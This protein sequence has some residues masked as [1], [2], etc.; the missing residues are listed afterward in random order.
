MKKVYGDDFYAKQMQASYES[1]KVYVDLLFRI[2]APAT[3]VDVGCGRGTWLK[4]FGEAGAKRLV[5]LDG[6]WNSQ[7]N[8]ADAAIAFTAVDLNQRL[9]MP[10]T[11]RFDVAM[12]L[13][14]AEHLEPDSSATF[15][16]SLTRL[17]DVVLFGAAFPGQG[18]A[19]HINEQLPSYWARLF[20]ERGYAPFDVFRPLVW[21]DDRVCFWYR[22]NAFLYIR[23][24]SEA[25][26][27]MRA[28]GLF[29]M[30]DT[31][32]MNCVHPE[33]LFERNRQSVSRGF[34]MIRKSIVRGI[35]GLGRGNDR[36]SVVHGGQA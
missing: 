12:S 23:E 4:A 29:P 21:N 18:G 34:K 9:S 2:F 20:H 16:E 13:E 5:G 3:V 17:S 8:M 6:R 27:T 26:E 19:N 15:V 10:G 22:Q 31:A 30:R 25:W 1:A 24:G 33:L 7:D 35:K 36:K 11:D 14:V 32:F 28:Q